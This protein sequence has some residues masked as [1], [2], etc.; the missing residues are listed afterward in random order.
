[1]TRHFDHFRDTQPIR[2]SLLC[3]ATCRSLIACVAFLGMA[4]AARAA[5][6]PSPTNL[7]KGKYRPDGTVNEERAHATYGNTMVKDPCHAGFSSSFPPSLNVGSMSTETFDSTLDFEVSFDGGVTFTQASANAA[8]TVVLTLDSIEG[9]VRNYS[10]VMTQL[11]AS[12]G[13]LPDGFMIRLSPTIASPGATTIEDVPG[14][15]IVDSHFDITTEMSPDGGV[16]WIPSS[17]PAVRMQLPP[18]DDRCLSERFAITEITVAPTGEVQLT[19]KVPRLNVP[20]T[21]QTS[22]D[23]ITFDDIPGSTFSPTEVE[24]VITVAPTPGDGPRRAFRVVDS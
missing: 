22:T 10:T 17:L 3:R 21:L 1:M 23:L 2:T 12:G 13:D 9:P 14:G 20:Y 6:C 16:T 11:D 24:T 8:V 18:G 7:P 5:Y 4:I 19:V 15:A